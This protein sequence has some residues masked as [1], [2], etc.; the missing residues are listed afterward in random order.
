MGRNRDRD[1]G[2]PVEPG[3]AQ[4]H[5]ND[6]DAVEI[7]RR[8]GRDDGSLGPNIDAQGRDMDN[9]QEGGGTRS[10]GRAREERA[11]ARSRDEGRGGREDAQRRSSGG[12]DESSDRGTSWISV[13]FGL[14]AALGASLI[15]SGIVGGIVGAILGAMG[16]GGGAEGGTAA[17]IGVLLTLLIAFI[18]GGYVA[19]RMASRSGLKHGLL[20]PLLLLALTI[21][22]AIIGTLVGASLIDN[23]QGVTLPAVPGG[24]Q[25]QAQGEAPQNLGTI[26]T[27]SGILALLVPFIGGAIGGSWGARTGRNRP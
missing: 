16:V 19:G 3:E 21:L 2:R 1:E 20:V 22:L 9:P 14:L 5:G 18:I 23:L 4:A 13:I 12:R 17:L 15:L 26:L 27:V 6:P 25:Q 8:G 7:N 11:E 10:V 24:V